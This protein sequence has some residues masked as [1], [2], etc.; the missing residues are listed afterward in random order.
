MTTCPICGRTGIRD[1][2]RFCPQCGAQLPATPDIDIDVAQ[3]VGTLAGGEAAGLRVERLSAQ[4]V[5]IVTNTYRLAPTGEHGGLAQLLPGDRLPVVRPAPVP[6]YVRPRASPGLLDRQA[7]VA[8]AAAA[9]QAN[10]PI[11]LHGEP[12]IGK[13]RLWR[14]LAH[15]AA[16]AGYPDGVVCLTPHQ[17]V[18]DLVRDLFHTFFDSGVPYVPALGEVR[19]ALQSK[20]A[21]VLLDDLKME[22]SE[23]DGL[24]DAVPNCGFVFASRERHLWVE[25]SA[26]IV[27]G[28]PLA[29]GVALIE[30]ELGR[31][32][33][34][35][36]RPSAE[37]I[38]G[39]LDGN[40]LRLQ[41]AA[42][43]VRDQGREVGAV[44]R[45]LQVTGPTQA[46]TGPLL[47][48]LTAQQ[49]QILAALAALQGASLHVRHLS[50]VVG[51]AD[52]T[53]EAEALR[54]RGL[55]KAHSPRYSLAGTL[56][57]EIALRWDLG[58]AREGMLAYVTAMA[59]GSR[60]HPQTILDE[61]D[62][63]TY[64]LQWA[65]E[66]GRWTDVLRL[67]R[68]VE[69]AFALG[70]RWGTWARILELLAQAARELGDQA[71][72]AWAL[73]Q[74]GTRA[75]C[76]H[77]AAPARQLLMEAFRLREELGDEA[78]A[79]VTRHNLDLLHPGP[80]SRRS[81]RHGRAGRGSLA[82][83]ITLPLKILL[84]VALVL[85]LARGALPALPVATITLANDN[86]DPI[87]SPPWGPIIGIS[88]FETIQSGEA[89]D[90]E[91]PALPGLRVSGGSAGDA[92]RLAIG[93][94]GL[95]VADFP[96]AGLTELRFDGDP[97]FGDA[98]LLD[99]VPR[100]LEGNGQYKIRASCR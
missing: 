18:E 33:T 25:G 63:A 6:V 2:A 35:A 9:L 7:E 22:R 89:R 50:P 67:G 65:A 39:S 74:L 96:V 95:T 29:E 24:I 86:C 34:P 77:E 10:R 41:Q 85:A 71:T 49:Q 14:H 61:I 12:G 42:A 69:P 87:S 51:V 83:L 16:T 46:L 43:L 37:S 98:T 21:L 38:C 23:V 97:L 31:P 36:E 17:P 53:Q 99:G 8:M 54:W 30:L 5:N 75:L 78:G 84:G 82:R 45:E 81:D 76:L 56:A 3:Q 66:T 52:V 44:A 57:D 15:H 60:D 13:T 92:P 11:E 100:S 93:L 48:G 55:V 59:E 91:V 88:Q 94:G 72:L 47:Q 28:L 80:V 27:R 73:H 4:T 40:P 32:L 26:V 58:P 70:G 20:R 62:A 19:R 90:I 64:M 79:A 1:T 68:A